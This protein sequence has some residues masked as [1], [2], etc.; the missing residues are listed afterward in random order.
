MAGKADPKK[1]WDRALR[2]FRDHP[3]EFKKYYHQRSNVE[4]AFSVMKRKFGDVVRAKMPVAQ[5]NE[6]LLKVLAHNICCLI[7]AIYELDLEPEFGEADL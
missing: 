4:T 7:R 2:F 3:D 1:L 5:E 6:V